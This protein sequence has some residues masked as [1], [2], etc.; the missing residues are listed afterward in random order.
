MSMLTSMSMS[1][2]ALMLVFASMVLSLIIVLVSISMNAGV[3]Y[4]KHV[5]VAL[6]VNASVSGH[7][8]VDVRE[9]SIG[10]ECHG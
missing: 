9:L 3:N 1:V 10:F 4:C 8:M 2:F 5:S 6:V 7:V